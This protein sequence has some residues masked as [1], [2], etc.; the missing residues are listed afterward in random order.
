MK[1]LLA[2]S[3]G[4]ALLGTA[5]IGAAA[6]VSTSNGEYSIEL[7]GQTANGGL[8]DFRWQI[9]KLEADAPGL[10]HVTFAL[11]FSDCAPGV[12][13][14][15]F[16][17]HG[18]VTQAGVTDSFVVLLAWNDPDTGLTGVSFTGL[19]WLDDAAGA[20][21]TF[22]LTL[23]P[24]AL[25]AGYRFGVGAVDFG[26]RAGEQSLLCPEGLHDP[27]FAT[28]LGP[29][30]ERIVPPEQTGREGLTPGYWKNHVSAWTAPYT[31]ATTLAQAGFNGGLFSNTTMLAALQGG[32]GAGLSGAQKILYR[33]AAAALL[34]AASPQVDYPLT[35]AQVIAQV[36]AAV[37]TG[38]R[39]TILALA[40]TLDAYNNLGAD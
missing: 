11:D 6:P 26:S 35:S 25:P 31:A 2:L 3:C 29:V 40:G 1:T 36:N 10:N 8:V 17:A 7:L 5:Q 21:A 13:L 23:D 34:N 22:T 4:L 28:V 32:G 38:N 12:P 19:Q 39:G 37:A 27:G 14:E 20:C 9:C 18:S 30:C 24:A 15:N 33:A 16:L